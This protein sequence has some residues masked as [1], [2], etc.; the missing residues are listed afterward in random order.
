[1]ARWDEL[2]QAIRTSDGVTW[3]TSTD[4]DLDAF[5]AARGFRLP[6]SYREFAKTFGPCEIGNT[7]LFFFAAP[8]YGDRSGMFNLDT[9]NAE[10]HEIALENAE[11]ALREDVFYDYANTDIAVRLVF[12]G[13]DVGGAPYGFDPE[14]VTDTAT[15][16]CAIYSRRDSPTNEYFRQASSLEEFLLGQFLAEDLRAWRE[17]MAAGCPGEDRRLRF[18]N[19]A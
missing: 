19:E 2:R 7:G 16:E 18:N 10:W 17:W 11:D 4:A 9:H 8:V 14:E 13:S 1:M 3:K 5:E 15:G 6:D 12:F